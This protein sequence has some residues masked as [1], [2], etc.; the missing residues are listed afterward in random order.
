M[1]SLTQDLLGYWPLAG[2][3]RDHSGRE[4]HGRPH[5]VAF[6]ITGPNGRPGR[7]AAFNGT[8]ACI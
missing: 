1:E 7:A 5:R 2:D 4:H 3:G 6:G 8:D